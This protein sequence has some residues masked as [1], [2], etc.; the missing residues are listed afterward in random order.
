MR[1]ESSSSIQQSWF[2][3]DEVSPLQGEVA[4]HVGREVEGGV[5]QTLVVASFAG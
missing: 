3:P 5:P 2:H 1:K 4:F